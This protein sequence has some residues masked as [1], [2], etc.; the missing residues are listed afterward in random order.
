MSSGGV[1]LVR[2]NNIGSVPHLQTTSKLKAES[3]KLGVIWLSAVR[4][5]KKLNGH[6]VVH[7]SVLAILVSVGIGDSL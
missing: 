1:S 3:L 7:T 2:V 4:S 5:N 6:S